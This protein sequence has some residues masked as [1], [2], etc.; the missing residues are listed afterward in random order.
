MKITVLQPLS[1]WMTDYET[2]VVVQKESLL[3]MLTTG[4]KDSQTFEEASTSQKWKEAMDT[5]MKAI[6]RNNTWDLV[7]PPEGVIPIGVKW[8]FKTKLNEKGEVDK[9]KARL[10]EKGYAKK[11]GINYTKVF[12]PVARLDT[13]RV[14]LVVAAQNAWDVFQLDVKS[15]FLHGEI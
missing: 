8:V 1:V 10:V 14:L 9:Y 12:A 7:D 2:N 3:A 4:C 13:V 5:E 11:Y 15:A 6:E